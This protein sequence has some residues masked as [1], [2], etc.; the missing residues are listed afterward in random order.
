M[1]VS[2]H[3]PPDEKW[4]QECWLFIRTIWN[5]VVI[6]MIKIA[7][8][9]KPQRKIKNKSI[10][11]CNLLFLCSAQNC[12][13]SEMCQCQR[14]M[15]FNG[16]SIIHVCFACFFFLSWAAVH[17]A[18][19]RMTLHQKLDNQINS[20]INDDNWTVCI[21]CVHLCIAEP[22]KTSIPIKML[23]GFSRNWFSICPLNM[24]IEFCICR[25]TIVVVAATVIW[26]SV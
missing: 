1:C 15:H 6:A 22:T 13:D 11:Q 8:M 17:I 10:H 25:F 14:V 9:K 18:G 21:A 20:I 19:H 16:G 23:I 3:F 12:N 4:C 26:L 24:L 5:G 7:P 2:A